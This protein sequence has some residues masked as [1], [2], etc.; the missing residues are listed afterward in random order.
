MIL[1]D[2]LLT[3]FVIPTEEWEPPI[4]TRRRISEELEGD[5]LGIEDEL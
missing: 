4:L 2:V 3:S 5:G 1:A